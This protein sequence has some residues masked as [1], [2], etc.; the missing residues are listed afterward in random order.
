[1]GEDVGDK[2]G[3]GEEVGVAKMLVDFGWCKC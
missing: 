1:M 3:G 2:E